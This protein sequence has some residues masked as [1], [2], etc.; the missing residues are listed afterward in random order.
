MKHLNDLEFAKTTTAIFLDSLEE[1]ANEIKKE[2][3]KKIRVNI[4]NN[5]V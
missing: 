3:E 4:K 5:R 1:E 2:T